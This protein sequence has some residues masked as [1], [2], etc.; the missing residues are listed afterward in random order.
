MRGPRGGVRVLR[1]DLCDAK[2]MA[3]RG[4][5]RRLCGAFGVEYVYSVWW[6]VIKDAMPVYEREKA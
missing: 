1:G 5:A 3:L 2:L 6:T 4:Q